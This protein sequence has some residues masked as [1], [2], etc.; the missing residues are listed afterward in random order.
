MV[1][2]ATPEEVQLDRP[3]THVD[4]R[5]ALEGPVGRVD[6]D[7]GQSVGQRRFVGRDACLAGLAGP[8]HERDAAGLPP[9]RRRPE[10]G[11]AEGVIEVAVGIDDGR[12]RSAGH[13]PNVVDDLPCLGVRRARIDDERGAGAEHEPDVLVVEGV[14]PHEGAVADLCPTVGGRHAAHGR[15]ARPVRFA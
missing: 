11:V 13:T 8:L 5:V 4:D 3:A 2:V 9:D 15:H 1:G 6:D 7:L 10:D 14:A 12:H